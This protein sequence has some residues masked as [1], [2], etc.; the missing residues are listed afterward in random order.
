MI[1]K[2]FWTKYFKRRKINTLTGN[3]LIARD[4][5][6]SVVLHC[7]LKGGSGTWRNLFNCWVCPILWKQVLF[8]WNSFLNYCLLSRSC[9][10]SLCASMYSIPTC[11]YFTVAGIS[12]QYVLY[13]ILASISAEPPFPQP[14]LCLQWWST[15]MIY[16]LVRAAR[17][18]VRKI[19]AR[20]TDCRSS[21]KF[22]GDF[23]W[24]CM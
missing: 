8:F 12:Y 11:I 9:V 7:Y 13:F 14:D 18:I 24:L 22:P 15:I 10:L 16:I 6:Y 2:C 3:L 17:T 23:F 1:S 4:D 21:C 5:G 19:H 20:P